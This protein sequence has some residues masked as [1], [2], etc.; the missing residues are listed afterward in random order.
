V[1]ALVEIKRLIGQVTTMAM[2]I[3]SAS[4]QQS[5][6]SADVARQVDLGAQK[7]AGNAEASLQLSATVATT[8]GTASQLTR[9]AEGLVALVERFRT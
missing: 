7:I 3:G 6:A 8:A 5:G 4:E 2:E 1:R 9:T